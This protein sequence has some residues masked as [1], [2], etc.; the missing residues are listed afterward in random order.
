MVIRAYQCVFHQ[1]LRIA[2]AAATVLSSLVLVPAAFG[3]AMSPDCQALPTAS[4][5]VIVGVIPNTT[6]RWGV[7]GDI[8]AFS[9]GTTSCNMGGCF[10]N[11]ISA[12]NDHPAIGQNMYRLK[13]G[14]FEQIGQSWLKHGFTALQQTACGSCS[15]PGSSSQ[16]SYLGVVCS[17][18]YSSGLN[19]GQSGLGPKFEVDA[20][21]GHFPY[22][23]TNSTGSG[24]IFK[25][26]QVHNT[27]LDPGQNVGAQYFVEAQYVSWDDATAKMHSNNVSYRAVNSIIGTPGSGVYDISLTGTASTSTVKEKSAIQAWKTA[28]PSVV[29]VDA[30]FPDGV[31]LVGAKVTQLGPTSWHYEYAIYNQ[32]SQR[33]VG[34]FSVPIGAAAVVTN[35]GFHDVDYH[36]GE[37]IVGTDWAPTV[38]SASVEWATQTFAVNPNANSLRWGTLYNFR[39]DANSPPRTGPVTLGLWRPG[40]PASVTVNTLVP[41]LCDFA[42]ETACGNTLDDDCDTQV[43]CA[44]SDCCQSS[45]C[46]SGDTDSDGYAAVCD[47]NNADA[48]VFP[49]APQLCDG[50]NNNCIDPSWPAVPAGEAD[51]D[52]DNVRVCA[53]DCDDANPQVWA[54][55]NEVQGLMLSY[56]TPSETA[57]L[58]WGTPSIPGGTF[59]HYDTLR[60]ESSAD[61]TNPAVCIETDGQDTTSTDTGAPVPGCN[62]YLVRARNACPSGVGVLGYTSDGTLKAGRTCP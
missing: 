59:V 10:L 29:L 55:P 19:G 28:D 11:W 50:K 46:V 21:S 34:T 35:L 61:F 54:T 9:I 13:N 60:S 33:A 25:R 49:G 12:T 1:N 48:S 53:S 57:L 38:L 2:L 4:P 27:D 31:V 16:P 39:F 8:T 51:A 37:P 41:T 17:D 30:N 52:G 7:V 20:S 24:A 23:F 32:N 62:S 45:A 36:S 58:A 5:D 26:L 42:T 44:D 22:P 56:D 43:D 15:R 14:R 6:S 18:P 40:T 3:H 47:C